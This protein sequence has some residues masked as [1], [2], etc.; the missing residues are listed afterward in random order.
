MCASDAEASV[1]LPNDDTNSLNDGFIVLDEEHNH[2]NRITKSNDIVDPHF[3][4]H[5]VSDPCVMGKREIDE[6]LCKSHRRSFSADDSLDTTVKRQ[7]R[8]GQPNTIATGLLHGKQNDVAKLRRSFGLDKS[9]IGE[10]VPISVPDIEAKPVLCSNK[11]NNIEMEAVKTESSKPGSEPSANDTLNIILPPPSAFADLSMSVQNRHE[12]AYDSDESEAGF[13]TISG[14]TVIHNPRTM[15][16]PEHKVVY[17]SISAANQQADDA[18]TVKSF[19]SVD[20]L[21][22]EQSET[23]PPRR[24]FSRSNSTDSGKGSLLDSSLAREEKELNNL[25]V[26]TEQTPLRAMKSISSQDLKTESTAVVNRSHS[27]LEGS[28]YKKNNIKPNLPI[29]METHKLLARAGY[30]EQKSL[31]PGT[32][33]IEVISGLPTIKRVETIIPRRESILNIKDAQNRK[34]EENVKQYEKSKPDSDVTE[35]HASALR[36]PNSVSRKRGCSPIRIPSV[37][38]KNEKD[39]NHLREAMHLSGMQK[40]ANGTAKLPISTNMLKPT[41]KAASASSQNRKTDLNNST[42]KRTPSIYY[43]DNDKR[44]VVKLRD[45]QQTGLCNLVEEESSITRTTAHQDASNRGKQTL[46]KGSAINLDNS[47]INT[48]NEVCTPL[49]EKFLRNNDRV[50]KS[51]ENS[52][53]LKTPIIKQPI[54]QTPVVDKSLLRTAGGNTPR[55]VIRKTHS[56]AKRSPMKPVKRLGSPRSS[57]C[58]SSPLRKSPHRLCHSPRKIEKSKCG[59][60]LSSVPGYL[61]E[62]LENL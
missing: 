36:F 52:D 8:R 35:R 49:S 15:T 53:G 32:V 54:I 29:C 3:P 48:I 59:T 19:D 57:P 27:M 28:M 38:L 5:S 25:L 46:L 20:S 45:N 60:V 40:L 4:H 16:L 26:D 30:M 9:E 17:R 43:A 1:F 2:L 50:G 14:G 23:S 39:I 41:E 10:P 34:V 37:F 61:Q 47:L 11:D 7:L 18:K 33:D 62:D 56:P 44:P 58:R 55:Y 31:K 13:S 24:D 12:K 21:F 22:S 42:C 6:S 51:K